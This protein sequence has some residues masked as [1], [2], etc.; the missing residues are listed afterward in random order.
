MKY[1][2]STLKVCLEEIVFIFLCVY[3]L[4]VFPHGEKKQRWNICLEEDAFN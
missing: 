3:K 2:K 4:M 1:M